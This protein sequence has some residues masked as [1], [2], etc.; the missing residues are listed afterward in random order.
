VGRTRVDSEGVLVRP[1][2][3][4]DIVYVL[5]NGGTLAALRAE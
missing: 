4:G 2:V 1:L 3:L 5:G